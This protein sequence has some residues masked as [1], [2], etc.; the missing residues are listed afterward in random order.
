MSAV[1]YARKSS[2]SEDRQIQSL[3]DQLAVLRGLARELGVSIET[4]F[5][6]S[7]SAKDPYARPE[8]ERLVTS[9]EQGTITE[10][11]TWALNRLS[12]NPVD[13]GRIAHLLQ[14]GNLNK[15]VT[16]TKVYDSEDSPLLLAV[17][18][19][20]STAFIQD[21]SRNV[22]RVYDSEDSPLLLAVEKWNEYG[23]HSGLES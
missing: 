3:G 22:K 6:E 4:E 15:I 12:R 9:I 10:V 21:L 23:V 7:K 11:F 17:E 16:P 18:N 2:E 20:M 13:G 8:F 19:G 1:I 14:K 5:L